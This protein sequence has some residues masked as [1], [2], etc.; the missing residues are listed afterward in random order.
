MFKDCKEE[1]SVGE[2]GRVRKSIPMSVGNEKP[3]IIRVKE[4]SVIIGK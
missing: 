1:K 4:L 3:P 2:N